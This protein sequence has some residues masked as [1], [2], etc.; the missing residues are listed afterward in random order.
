MNDRSILDLGVLTDPCRHPRHE[1]DE[2]LT[3]GTDH[4]DRGETAVRQGVGAPDDQPV[5]A[6]GVPR[7]ATTE[8]G[9]CACW[10]WLV[11]LVRQYLR[12]RPALRQRGRVKHRL[13]E[14][15]GGPG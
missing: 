11:I 5:D 13:A 9:D 12:H 15:I 14:S 1:V 7:V 3:L 8:D 10:P 6:F 2:L 4:F